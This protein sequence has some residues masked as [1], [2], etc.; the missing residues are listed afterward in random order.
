MLDTSF[1]SI[2]TLPGAEN[3]IQMGLSTLGIICLRDIWIQGLFS[4]RALLDSP[5]WFSQDLQSW[6]LHHSKWRYQLEE[7]QGS[8][9]F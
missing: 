8:L 5:S 2:I 1:L 6:V 4:V 7:A 3:L 9:W